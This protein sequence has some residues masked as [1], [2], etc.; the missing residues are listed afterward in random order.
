MKKD[1][2]EEALVILADFHANGDRDDPLVRL[3]YMEIVEGLESENE[4]SQVSYK[5]Y[6]LPRNRRRLFLI[7][8]IAIGTNWV[9]N[10]II[11]Y[12]LSPILK[13]VGVPSTEDQSK[14]NLGLQ[15]WNCETPLPHNL[16]PYHR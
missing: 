13:Q 6:L 15:C 7:I 8:A 16:P 9:G 3:E 5:D 2:R 12:Y 4:N 14:F 11:S 10:G 1:R